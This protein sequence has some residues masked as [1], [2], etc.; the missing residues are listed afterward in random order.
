MPT[1]R[2]IV[3]QNITQS[4]HAV[5]SAQTIEQAHALA[6]GDLAKYADTDA[7]G[8]IRWGTGS[9]PSRQDL[10]IVDESNYLEF[11]DERYS[12]AMTI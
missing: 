3:T 5:V 10:Y 12:N 8:K 9:L 4:T 2:F 11:E 6:L 7:S 1:F